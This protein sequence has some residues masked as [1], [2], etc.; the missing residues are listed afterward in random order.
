[1]GP[2]CHRKILRARV[3]NRAFQQSA[4][5]GWSHAERLNELLRELLFLTVK[6]NCILS[7]EW[8]STHAN[9]LA[10]PLSRFDEGAFLERA[11]APGSSVHG[12]LD[13]HPD[14]GSRR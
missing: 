10:D 3:D 9:T 8:I 13:R 4:V 2:D 11:N 12:P 14:A 6:F 7:Y 1:M 5:K